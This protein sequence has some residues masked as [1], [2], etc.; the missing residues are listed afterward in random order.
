MCGNIINDPRHEEIVI[1]FG[2]QFLLFRCGSSLGDGV[3]D[4]LGMAEFL[5]LVEQMAEMLHLSACSA[6]ITD[7][8]SDRHEDEDRADD[9]DQ[10][11]RADLLLPVDLSEYVVLHLGSQP[12]EVGVR[13]AIID[14]VSQVLKAVPVL[15][16]GFGI[17]AP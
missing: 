15:E 7:I 4:T 9:R 16:R 8:G 6:A 12:C 5:Y 17:N 11:D 3:L 14:R 10:D 13:F 1:R 2:E